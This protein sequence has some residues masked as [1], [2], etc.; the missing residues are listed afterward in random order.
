MK[1]KANKSAGAIKT[2]AELKA[3]QA[4][5]V[6]ALSTADR[7][8]MQKYLAMGV[9][10]G[11]SIKLLRQFPC[12]VFQVGHTQVAVDREMAGGILVKVS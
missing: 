1:K 9:L 8:K 12:F 3:G 7:G 5:R 6:A 4:G 10:P 2:L 11:A